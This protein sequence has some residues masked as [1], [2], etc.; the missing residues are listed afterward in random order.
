MS[1]VRFRNATEFLVNFFNYNLKRAVY[2][3]SFKITKIHETR[4][5]RR[6]MQSSAFLL[7]NRTSRRALIRQYLDNVLNSPAFCKIKVDLARWNRFIKV[8]S[9]FSDRFLL[10]RRFQSVQAGFLSSR[11]VTTHL[12]KHIKLSLV[13]EFERDTIRPIV[14]H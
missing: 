7:Y 9:I 13:T 3:R 5:S 10:S 12:Y 6:S 8:F 2:G 11:R 1:A 14:N 4:P